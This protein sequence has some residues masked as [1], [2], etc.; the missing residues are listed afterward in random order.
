MS[1]LSGARGLYA[2]LDPDHTTGREP[3]AIAD[4]ILAAGPAVLQLRMKRASDRAIVDLA[5]ELRARCH[6]AGVPFVLNDRA[7]LA[8]L[9][10]ADG[11]HLG[12]DDLPTAAARRV[13]GTMPLGRSTHDLAQ[14][15]EA[16]REGADLIGFGPVFDTATKQNP[17]PT[18]GLALLAQVVRS[19]PIPVVGIGGITTNRVPDVAK[20]G[21]A[22]FAVISAIG[23]APDPREAARA[24]IEAWGAG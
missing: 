18:V 14:A 4:A 3:L 24:L 15:L 21:S 7:D 19:V 17:D 1:F 12:Q 11:V 20:S 23:S 2:I 5:R 13:I 22:F 16:V 10:D 6:H 8:R 9:V